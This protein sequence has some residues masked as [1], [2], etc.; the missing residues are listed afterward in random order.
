MFQSTFHLN[1][2][3][4]RFEDFSVEDAVLQMDFNGYIQAEELAPFTVELK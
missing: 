1:G 2:E 3:E 4:Q